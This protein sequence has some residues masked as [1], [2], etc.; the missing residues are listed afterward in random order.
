MR[1]TSF[2]H[3]A[4][5]IDEMVTILLG[6]VYGIQC[7]V[8]H[9]TPLTLHT[10]LNGFI[11]GI[12]HSLLGRKRVD[13]KSRVTAQES[14]AKGVKLT[15]AATKFHL[16]RVQ[17]YQVGGVRTHTIAFRE[18][19]SDLCIK[20]NENSRCTVNDISSFMTVSIHSLWLTT[21]SSSST[22]S[23]SSEEASKSEDRHNSHYWDYM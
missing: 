19:I 12:I 5:A 14:F 17:S 1:T 4:R 22:G 20:Q 11:R 10:R 21:N 6:N 15:V 7:T 13:Q 18:R 2:S 9:S 23:S 3:F 16:E 8:L